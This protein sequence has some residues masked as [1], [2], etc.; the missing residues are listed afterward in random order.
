MIHKKK[1]MLRTILAT[2]I[3][4]V[5]ADDDNSCGRGTVFDSASS[6]CV[7]DQATLDKLDTLAAILA[8]EEAERGRRVRCHGFS[9]SLPPFF[10]FF[11]F[12]FT[13]IDQQIATSVGE[14]QRQC[15]LPV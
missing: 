6:T 1:I 7:V 2:I 12:L 14:S 5:A 11:F 13:P 15:V 4:V 8:R 10:F 3:V 9:Y